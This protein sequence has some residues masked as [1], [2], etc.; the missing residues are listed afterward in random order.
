[1]DDAR[2][3]RRRAGELA[4][5]VLDGESEWT[6]R[7]RSRI[8]SPYGAAT[9]EPRAT[10]WV[11][12]PDQVGALKG[13]H[14]LRAPGVSLSPLQGS[15]GLCWSRPRAL[16]WAKLFRPFGAAVIVLINLHTGFSNRVHGSELPLVRDGASSYTIYHDPGA[17]SSVKLAAKEL[18][19]V[20]EISTGAKLSITNAP[21]SP[22]IALGTGL[23]TE[24]L[25][26][27]AFQIVTKGQDLFIAGNDTPDGQQ[28]WGSSVGAGTSRGTLFG[29][30]SFL[31]KV[32]GVRWLLPG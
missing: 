12:V 9:G 29:V 25:P 4:L 22:M 16:P 7:M 6:D 26:E 8:E 11:S 24:T 27:E 14:S 31:E 19:R 5:G 20:L 28:T 30:Y 13:R 3:L 17:P 23:S 32:V 18:Q 15:S 10:P 21:A 1:M 2:V